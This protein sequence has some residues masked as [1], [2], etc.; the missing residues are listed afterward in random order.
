MRILLVENDRRET[1][2][3]VKA[4]EAEQFAVDSIL[5]ANDSLELAIGTQYDAIILGLDGA[6]LALLTKLRSRGIVTP[7]LALDDSSSPDARC[8]ALEVGSDDCLT[9]P[10]LLQE[11]TIRVRA[12]LRRP[13]VLVHKLQVGDLELDSIRR[14]AIRNG[15]SVQLT[16]KEFAILE[17]LMRNAGRPVTRT[18]LVEHVWNGRFEGL[19]SIVDVYIN[20]LRSKLD[21]GFDTKL[22]R[23]AH[24]V[25]YMIVDHLEAAV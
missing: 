15:K 6:N 3:I 5:P 14:R 24:G 22:I 12:L 20:Y 8:R 21:K 19:A 16:P 1:R 7:I 18:M 25:G 23:T 13:T 10:F 17:Y 2:A 9:K 4:L 11:L